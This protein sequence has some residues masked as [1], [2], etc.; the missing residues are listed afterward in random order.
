MIISKGEEQSQIGRILAES[1]DFKLIKT[2]IKLTKEGPGIPY[3]KFPKQVKF[4]TISLL[5]AFI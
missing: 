3:C 4:M 5:R 2:L 1:D